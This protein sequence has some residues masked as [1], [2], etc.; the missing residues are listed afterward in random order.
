MPFNH[1]QP[2]EDRDTDT[3]GFIAVDDD[4]I[5]V[6][7]RGT[8]G[9]SLADWITDLS[10][11]HHPNDVHGGK[12]HRGFWN[13]WLGVRDLVRAE[14]K[15]LRS[16][17]QHIWFTGHSLGGALATLGGRDM[18]TSLRPVGIHTFGAP[19]VGNHDYVENFDVTTYRFVNEDDIV[20]HVPSRGLINTYR[21][22]GKS[23]VMLSD[24]TITSA[25]VAW[26]RALRHIS[27][28]A[29]FGVSSL[30]AKSIGDHSMDKYIGKLEGHPLN[31]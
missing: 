30:P 23:F 15:S 9:S 13:A 1:V 26:R 4:N 19:R 31:R 11:R 29:I 24:G 14:V 10:Y 7:F 25:E 27:Q 12:V 20:P 22:L 5:V 28:I 17:S 3:E 6:A 2:F 8:E 18:P 21:H 16:N